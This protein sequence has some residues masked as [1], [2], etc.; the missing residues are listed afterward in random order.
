MRHLRDSALQSRAIA[1]AMAANRHTWNDPLLLD[2][3]GAC[4]R[5]A[6]VVTGKLRGHP[7][8]RRQADVGVAV[9][10]RHGV[11]AAWQRCRGATR[12]RVLDDYRTLLRHL[13]RELDDAR[14]LT[15]SPDLSDGFG[16]CRSEIHELVALLARKG[17]DSAASP[18]PRGQACPMRPPR[19]GLENPR[20]SGEWPYLSSAPQLESPACSALRC[21]TATLV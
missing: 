2:G 18:C 11:L 13:L 20:H 5:I 12:S 6:R 14:A 9:R 21:P 3:V 8:I 17:G 10:L 15:L 19:D 1:G 4:W 7:D 16:R